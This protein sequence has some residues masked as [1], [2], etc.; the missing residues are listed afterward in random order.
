MSERLYYFK[1]GDG[2]EYGPI[3][4]QEVAAWQKQG[5]MNSESLVRYEDSNDWVP[6]G[7]MP[8]LSSSPPPPPSNPQSPSA[9]SSGIG[10]QMS[11]DEQN[12]DEDHRGGLVLGLGIGGLVL[13]IAC[14]CSLPIPVGLLI[15]LPAWVMGSIDMRKMNAGKMDPSGKG[16][17]KGGL[18][19][20]IIGTILS[21]MCLLLLIAG[22][23]FEFS[24]DD[25]DGFLR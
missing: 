9:S 16:N 11:V 17:T 25:F 7:R 21:L 18:I 13:S 22:I 24:S 15:A 5:R 10:I 19:C 14:C 3:S 1:A 8:E 6:L 12:Y 23:L 4:A 20:G 2:N